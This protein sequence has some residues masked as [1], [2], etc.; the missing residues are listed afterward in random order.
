MSSDGSRDYSHVSSAYQSINF[1]KDKEERA[2]WADRNL[3]ST[4]FYDAVS[5]ENGVKSGPCWLERG[6]NDSGD[7][8]VR[9]ACV[10]R[11]SFGCEADLKLCDTYRH[12]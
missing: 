4:Q 3:P 5:K 1:R 8:S 9:Y 12:I 10:A 11:I 7:E 2:K 6:F